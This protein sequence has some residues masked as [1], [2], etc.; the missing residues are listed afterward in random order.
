M[1]TVVLET[2]SD[3]DISENTMIESEGEFITVN[4]RR[5]CSQLSSES[6]ADANKPRKKFSA[7]ESNLVVKSVG[8][9]RLLSEINSMHISRDLKHIHDIL[10]V[11]IILGVGF[12]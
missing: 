12:S 11:K 9:S 4:R 7:V 10:K 3:E 5:R 1:A 6:G 8:S 2:N